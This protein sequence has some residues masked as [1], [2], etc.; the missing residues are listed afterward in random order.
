M[1]EHKKEREESNSRCSKLLAV[2]ESGMVPERE[3]E[4]KYLRKNIQD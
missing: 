1:K 4:L 2:R 3:L